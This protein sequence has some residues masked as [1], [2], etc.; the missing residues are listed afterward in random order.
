MFDDVIVPPELLG[1][2]PKVAI[3]RRNQWMVDVC[4]YVVTCVRRSSGGSIPGYAV[5]QKEGQM[6]RQ[7]LR[8]GG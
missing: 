5:C 4:D 8:I 2:Y 3:R 7:S 6:V 1:V